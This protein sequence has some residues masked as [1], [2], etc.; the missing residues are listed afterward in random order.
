MNT[1]IQHVAQV[2]EFF[3]HLLEVESLNF[4]PDE[5]FR[6]YI[7]MEGSRAKTPS[8]TPEEADLRN[9][10]LAQCFE[11]CERAEVDIYDIGYQLFYGRL[12][13]ALNVEAE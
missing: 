6:N 9:D 10:I 1:K 5:H 3:Q 12:K 11:V 8:Y 13:K 2:K 4:H 7:C